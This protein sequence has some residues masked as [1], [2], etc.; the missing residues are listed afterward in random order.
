[1]VPA[2]GWFLGVSC[3]FLN[4]MLM[5][6][7]AMNG[8]DARDLVFVKHLFVLPVQ[9]ST[10]VGWPMFSGCLTVSAVWLINAIFFYRATGIA[11]PLWWPAAAFSLFL[12]T[13]QALAWT[14]FAQRWLHI[15]LT[16]AVLISPLLLLIVGLNLDLNPTEPLLAALFLALIPVAY[17]AAVSGVARAR[18]GAPYD[19]RA[20]GRFV[21]WLARWR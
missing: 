6:S 20:W 9:T 11:A 3:L 19:W 10:L 17:V 8:T 13:I 21:E 2:V 14:P 4:V 5:A 12:V 16:I 7:F 18:R 15:A 1:Q